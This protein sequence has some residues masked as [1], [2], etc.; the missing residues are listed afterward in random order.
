MLKLAE[1][2]I[3]SVFILFYFLAPVLGINVFVCLF[4]YDVYLREKKGG[5]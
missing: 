1:F 2:H 5:E 3:F 4:V